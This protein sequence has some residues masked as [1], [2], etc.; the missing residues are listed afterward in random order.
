MYARNETRPDRG[1]GVDAEGRSL[2]VVKRRGCCCCIV[3][4]IATA[5]YHLNLEAFLYATPS[6]SADHRYGFWVKYTYVTGCRRCAGRSSGD[7]TNVEHISCARTTHLPPVSAFLHIAMTGG[8][9]GW[10][11]GDMHLWNH[12]YIRTIP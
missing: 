12:T 11:R 1:K 6:P 3:H 8:L 9:R 4:C 2:S 10:R 5:K 7:A